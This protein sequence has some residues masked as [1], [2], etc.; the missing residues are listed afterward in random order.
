MM[1]MT[2]YSMATLKEFAGAEESARL[3]E[4]FLTEPAAD[5]P[6]RRPRPASDASTSSRRNA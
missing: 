2:G 5:T 4:S 6:E 3:V 1:A